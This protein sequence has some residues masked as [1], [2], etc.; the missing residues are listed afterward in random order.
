MYALILG[1][2]SNNTNLKFDIDKYALYASPHCVVVV[3]ALES[4]GSNRTG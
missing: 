4:R 3:G 2:S 1:V